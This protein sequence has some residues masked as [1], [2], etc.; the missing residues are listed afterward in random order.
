MKYI[1]SFW[2]HRTKG[3]KEGNEERNCLMMFAN[4]ARSKHRAHSRHRLNSRQDTSKHC[5]RPYISGF[6]FRGGHVEYS[7]PK[8]FYHF[9]RLRFIR[10]N[11]NGHFHHLQ[12]YSSSYVACAVTFSVSP[13]SKTNCYLKPS[14]QINHKS[15][16][17]SLKTQIVR[18]ERRK[19]MIKMK[20]G[21][22][23]KCRSPRRWCSA[24]QAHCSG[25]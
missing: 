5:L 16:H 24:A 15:P 7:R 12:W 10:P 9:C 1:Y 4:S 3:S 18:V 8:W 17:E 6:P 22:E 25:R 13:S 21:K 23:K 11:R 2:R 19:S 20:S 14:T